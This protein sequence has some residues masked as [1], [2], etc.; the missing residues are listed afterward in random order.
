[1]KRIFSNHPIDVVIHLA[2]RAGVRPSLEDPADY[3]DINITGTIQM[4]E[5]MKK[6]GCDRMVFASSSSVY[7]SR[8]K[9][10][11]RETDS[12]DIPASPYAATKACWRNY[13]QT[14]TISIIF[15]APAFA[16]SLF[17][18]Q[19]NDQKMAIH[20]FADKIRRGNEINVWRWLFYP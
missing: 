7:G 15:K 13:L 4:L 8:T 18:V 19:D 14:I 17:M 10:P 6:Y 12:V 1:M 2:A 16:S 20:L 3:S 5:T 11:F 9:G